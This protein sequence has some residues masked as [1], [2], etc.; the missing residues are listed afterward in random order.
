[1]FIDQRILL[2]DWNGIF[3]TRTNTNS[4]LGTVHDP[5]IEIV[6]KALA[7]WAELLHIFTYSYLA[8]INSF[9]FACVQNG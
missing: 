3:A 5:F 9:L 4:C 8:A 7:N 1:M 2:V 6:E